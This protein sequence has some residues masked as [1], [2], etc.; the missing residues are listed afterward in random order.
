MSITKAS[1][2]E[3]MHY[4][5]PYLLQNAFKRKQTLAALQ[6]RARPQSFKCREVVKHLE[7]R[8][9]IGSSFLLTL[10]LISAP[11]RNQDNDFECS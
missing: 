11:V 7:S 9:S 8:P 6:V 4:C 5:L 3:V 2:M 10:L 1:H